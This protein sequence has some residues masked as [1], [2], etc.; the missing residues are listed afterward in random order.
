MTRKNSE[1]SRDDARVIGPHGNAIIQRIIELRGHAWPL[2]YLM[3]EI[4]PDFLD[5]FD[6]TYRY[7]L[8]FEDSGKKLTQ[9]DTEAVA[10]G[11]AAESAESIGLPIR[12][13]ELI[14][15]CACA[16][17]PAPIEVTVHHLERA[18]SSG[19]TEREAL[20]GFQALL[21]PSGGV[22]VSNGA[23][24]LLRYRENEMARDAGREP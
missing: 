22:A 9:A 6:Q 21:I 12:Y 1:A 17:Q 24:A 20:E 18:F 16:I 13:R 19:L 11:G 15:A 10:T 3:A 2:H 5:L 14:C 23:R 7:T 8:G 4:D